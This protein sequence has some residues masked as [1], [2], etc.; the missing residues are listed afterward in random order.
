M[1]ALA[2]AKQKIPPVAKTKVNPYFNS[3]YADLADIDQAV[4]PVLAEFGL[5]VTQW[6]EWDDK[7][8]P[9]LITLLA[10]SSGEFI[11]GS[12]PLFLGKGEP[13]MQSL[14]SAETYARRYAFGAAVNVSTD[15]DDDGNEASRGADKKSS[16]TAVRPPAE[17]DLD[18]GEVIPMSGEDRLAANRRLIEERRRQTA[19]P[20]VQHA[21]GVATKLA[22]RT[23]SAPRRP[24]P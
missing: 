1:E 20:H 22:T 19:S 10:H 18:T 14:G 5:A 2:Q 8:R 3:R 24:M 9:V 23:R 21:Q 7:D 12:H 15:E 6:A 11:Q 16:P 13:T 4:S 17:A